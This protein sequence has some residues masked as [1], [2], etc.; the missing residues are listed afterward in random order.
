MS[1][2]MESECSVLLR[3]IVCQGYAGQDGATERLERKAFHPPPQP[4]PAR[5]EGV[6]RAGGS[7]PPPP[8]RGNPP[9]LRG[10]AG[11]GVKRP[12]PSTTPSSHNS[13]PAAVAVARAGRWKD[14]RA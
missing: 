3:V 10:R 9:P 13:L 6:A 5:G 2:R 4:S 8:A 12:G 14:A 7:V 11:R 1:L